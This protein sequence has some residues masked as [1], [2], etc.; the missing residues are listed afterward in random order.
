MDESFAEAGGVGICCRDHGGD[1]PPLVLV[2]A[3]GFHGRVWDPF[4]P[5][6]T[7][8]FRVIT[9]D[10]RGHGDSDK[11]EGGYEWPRFGEDV[12]A[13][14][15]HL[16][17]EGPAALGHSA[18]AAALVLAESMR[19]GTFSRLV[20]MDPVTPRADVRRFFSGEENPLARSSLKRRRVWD[21]VDQM[22]E[23]LAEGSPLR[24]WREEFLRAYVEHGTVPRADGT[25]ELK[26]PP[27]VEAQVY[28]M[29][30]THDA[31]ERLAELRCPVLALVGED[32]EMWFDAAAEAL[33]KQLRDGRVERVPGGHFFPMEEPEATLERV[34]PFL[35]EAR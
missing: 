11:P 18:G 4:L 26:C 21:S 10:Q 35:E 31:W 16:G 25:I 5:A 3:T 28:M 1:G 9:L 20:L 8:R 15:D 32:S 14:V 29:G 24:G 12:L 17:L 13:A 34:L 22:V 30:G 33:G 6:L 19:P 27:E 23:R 7:E 2:H